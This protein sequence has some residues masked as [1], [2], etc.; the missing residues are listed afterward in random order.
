[1]NKIIN[2]Y[3][4]DGDKFMPELHLRQPGFNHSACG[5]FTKYGK[6]IRKFR[7]TSNL[8]YI[9]NNELD[10]TCFVHDLAYSNSKD[11]AKRAIS[12]KIVKS[13]LMKLL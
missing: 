1:M 3:L 9:Y 7:E 13:E 11:L 12:D 2:K 4:L 6:T 5:P 8:R 10:K